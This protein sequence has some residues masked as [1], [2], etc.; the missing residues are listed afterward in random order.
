MSTDWKEKEREFLESLAPDTGRDLAEW[1][2]LISAQ[3]LAHRNDMID[4]LRHQGFTFS[5]ASWLERIHHNG[6][7]P[8]YLEAEDFKRGTATESPDP[9]SPAPVREAVPASATP[10]MV[11][12][13]D[14]PA[15]RKASDQP[16]AD[17]R[18][19]ASAETA[20]PSAR[21]ATGRDASQPGAMAIPPAGPPR[22]PDVALAEVL[23][24]AKAYRPLATY[25]LREIELALPGLVQSAEGA[26]IVLAAPR[27]FAMLVV[28][29]K[30]LRL[31]LALDDRPATG[32]LAALKLPVTMARFTHRMTHMV[33]LTDAR[34]VDDTLL[35]LVREAA[36]R[37]EG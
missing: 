17:I 29:G 12:A 22:P 9:E 14:H 23:A 27:P 25:V 4:W 30:D 5:R 37:A 26:G 28:S 10:A 16:A 33:V 6:G 18:Q 1:M 19:M 35:A 20:A 3:R 13:D 7:N 31:A 11:A 24:K 2:A 34:Q 15:P 8:I 32:V 36:E 21:G